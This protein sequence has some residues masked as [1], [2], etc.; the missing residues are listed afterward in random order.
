MSPFIPICISSV[1]GSNKL[2]TYEDV[3]LIPLSN[4]ALAV[5]SPMSRW[6]PKRLQIIQSLL[7]IFPPV[8][9]LFEKAFELT[10]H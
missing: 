8:L 6:A 2:M 5:G 1:L 4:D 9:A 3:T 10:M 7:S